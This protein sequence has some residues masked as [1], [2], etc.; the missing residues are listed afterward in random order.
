MILSV[1]ASLFAQSTFPVNGIADPK[2]GAYAFTNA[3]IVKDGATTI[4][5]GTMII[6][7]GKIVATGTNIFIPKDAVVIDCEGKYIYPSFIDIYSD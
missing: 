6:R 7:E 4:T 5:K 1:P 3:T 2:D